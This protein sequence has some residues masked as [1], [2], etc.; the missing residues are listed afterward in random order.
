M[1]MKYCEHCGASMVKYRHVMNLGYVNSLWRLALAGG[2][3]C[4]VAKIG[5]D[6]V[7]YSAFAKMRLWG[8]ITPTPG[9]AGPK[10]KGGFWS[11]SDK[12][13]AFLRG[14]LD[15]PRYVRS[16][17]AKWIEDSKELINIRDVADGWWYKADHVAA[18]EP[19]HA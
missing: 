16:Y 12:G 14:E 8:L 4:D 11:L 1:A 15:V 18:A 13:W 5:L 2:V 10:K 19:Y 9:D 7:E 3:D 17:R 6:N